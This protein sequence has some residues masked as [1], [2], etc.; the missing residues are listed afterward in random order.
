MVAT[1]PV[2]RRP[3]WDLVETRAAATPTDLMVSDLEGRSLSFGEF[4]LDAERQA[5]GLLD[6]G[7]HPGE[8]VAWILPTCI[9]ALV[10]VAALARLDSVQV[11]LLP[12][13]GSKEIGH[14][15]RTTGVS[16]VITAKEF[17][18]I[19]L[20]ERVLEAAPDVELLVVDRSILPGDPA[21]LP[22]LGAPVDPDAVRWIFHTSGT[23]SDPKGAQHSDGSVVAC[24]DALT[25]AVELVPEDRTSIYFPFAHIGGV[26]LLSL[27]LKHGN[28]TT[29]M[30]T[31]DG[32]GAVE[33]ME[34]ERVTLAG[35]GTVFF[36]AYIKVREA[37]ERPRLPTVRAFMNGGAPKNEVVF[38]RLV[39][40]FGVGI[41]S[42]YGLTEC[43]NI[44]GCRPSMPQARQITTEGW[45]N[46]GVEISV[47]DPDGAPVPTS[48]PGELWVRAPQ[49][50]KGYVDEA[51]ND[52]FDAD[53]YFRTGDL[54]TVDDE[55]Y[56]TIV[57]RLKDVIVR[58]GENISAQEVELLAHRHPKIKDVAVIGVP[59]DVTGERCCAVVV[60]TDDGDPP[61][62]EEL[63]RFLRAEGLM[64]QKCPEAMVVVDTLPRSSVGKV[65]KTELRAWLGSARGSVDNGRLADLSDL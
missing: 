3:Y 21:G 1:Q 40:A 24:A 37:S 14:A 58:K 27:T 36:D 46:P 28:A 43:P 33:L 23:T 5:A 22:P 34:R 9:E 62:V 54:V 19:D 17:R 12:I 8:T 51:L 55:G 11:P 65:L 42:H 59:D 25:A 60:P 53:G 30:E 41:L 44:T 63:A 56:V 57:G 29:V 32:E 13:Y 39:E 45:P 7:L 26:Q 64:I 52:A 50:C 49:L 2:G 16:T 20:V 4:R 18:G 10:L 15:L 31:F 47:R 61:S 6:A 48:C 35:A 38:R